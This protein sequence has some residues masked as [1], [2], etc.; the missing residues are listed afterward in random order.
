[1]YPSR[2]NHNGVPC[3]LRALSDVDRDRFGQLAAIVS[4][5]LHFTPLLSGF[6]KL[7]TEQLLLPTLTSR[8][9]PH[10]ECKNGRFVRPVRNIDRH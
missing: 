7:G 5:V 2:T 8:V 9:V 4:V 3:T 10:D 6:G 1:M